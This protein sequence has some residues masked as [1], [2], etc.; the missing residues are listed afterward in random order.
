MNYVIYYTI[1]WEGGCSVQLEVMATIIVVVEVI[2]IDAID[3]IIATRI[4]KIEQGT[5]Q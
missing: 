4:G 2:V 3:A 1:K 5:S